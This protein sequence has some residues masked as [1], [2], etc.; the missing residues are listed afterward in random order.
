LKLSGRTHLTVWL[1][2]GLLATYMHAQ[3]NEWAPGG[4]VLV[5]KAGVGKRAIVLKAEP[6]RCLVAYEGTDQQFDEW[7]EVSWLRP[8]K[9]RMV[10][11]AESAEPGNKPTPPATVSAGAPPE[12][13]EPVAEVM[14]ITGT[15][16]LPRPA[17]DAV[18]VPVWLEARP[19][20]QPGEA[21][22]FNVAQLA[23]PMF[24]LPAGAGIPS[25]RPPTRVVALRGPKG[26]T[27]GFAAVEGETVVV[28]RPE[29]AGQLVPVSRLDLKDFGAHALTGLAAGD[30]NNDGSPDLVVI[31]GPVLQVFFTTADGRQVAS[32]QAYRGKRPL[33]APVTGQFF[34]GVNPRGIAVVEGDNEFRLLAAS[35]GGVTAVNEPYAVK[36]DR[37]VDL[38]AGDFDGDGFTDLAVATE[39]KGRSTGAWMYFNQNSASQAFIWPV[40]GKDDFA[41]AL[42][43]ADLDRDGRDDLIMTDNDADRGEQVRV[44]FGSAGRSGWEDPWEVIGRELGVGLGTG[45]VVTGDFNR[46]GR[47]DIGVAGR[48]GLRIYP[49][50][51]YRRF[52][53]N[54]VWPALPGGAGLPDQQAFVAG[55]FNG[56]GAADVLGYT[57]Q[58][59]TGYNLLVN[60]TTENPAGVFVPPPLKRKAPVQAS[61]TVTKV[62][63]VRETPPGTPELRFLASRAEP[64]GPYRYRIV[65]EVA[66]SDDGVVQAVEGICKY[67]N[68]GPLQEIAANSQRLSDDQWSLEVVLPRGRN[69]E[70]T[71]TARDDQGG[72][73]LPLRVAVSP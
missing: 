33:R 70:F 57:P 67:A 42:A 38:R 63:R 68:E 46:D 34:T 10:E 48:N 32:A 11:P 50:A 53:R 39:T 49:G 5:D 26:R 43:V 66:A 41:R 14:A 56:D 22:Q 6:G 18:I 72:K 19:R 16:A 58:F 54:P 23:R 25:R 71:I 69:Y 7:V 24:A 45:A 9:P 60:A 55:D 51:D 47:E 1:L 27:L 40:G 44:V 8:V 15:Q 61:S 65:V 20:S 59:A 36:F 37:V 17:A 21:L 28:Y 64:Y 52:G 30:L 29:A 73:S 62:E 31:G 12:P 4:R 13:P 35:P 2:G 3:E